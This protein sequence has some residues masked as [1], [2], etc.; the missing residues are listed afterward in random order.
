MNESTAAIRALCMELR[1]Q[2]G[3]QDG[4]ADPEQ[5]ATLQGVRIRYFSLG[6]TKGFYVVLDGIPFIAVNRDLPEPLRQIVCAHELGHHFLHRQLA[7]ETLLTDFDLYRMETKVE[8]EA[9][10]F[11]SFLLV[12]G[13]A[14]GFLRRPENRSISIQEA[15]GIFGTTEELLAIRLQAEG[16][17]TDARVSR[18]PV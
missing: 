9:N 7:E 13:E 4:P 1:A 18:F 17:D 5:L 6:E 3:L 11:A 15:A 8:R 14:V 12:S 16:Y 2:A 10:L